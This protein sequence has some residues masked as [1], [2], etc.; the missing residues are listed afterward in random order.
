MASRILFIPTQYAIYLQLLG[1]IGIAQ[2]LPSVMLGAYTRWFNDWALLVGWAMGIAFGT[3]M[4]AATD[5]TRLIRCKSLAS[6]SPVYA[7]FTVILNI[8]VAAVLTPV[9]NAIGAQRMP[10]DETAAS[11]YQAQD[12]SKVVMQSLSAQHSV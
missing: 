2:T 6:P 9:F 12:T 5:L 7:L 10:F 11:D 8:A 4:A 3:L 1:G